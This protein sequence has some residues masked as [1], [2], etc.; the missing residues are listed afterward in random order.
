MVHDEIESASRVVDLFYPDEG[1]RNRMKKRRAAL[2]DLSKSYIK[3][4]ELEKVAD[5]ICRQDQYKLIRL[6]EELCDEPEIIAYRQDVLED[7]ISIPKLAGTVKQIV[8]I[9]IENDRG[10]IYQLSEP[11]SFTTLSEA[12][13]AFDAYVECVEIMHGFYLEHSGEIK[14]E[15]VKRLFKYFEDGYADED[16]NKMKKNLQELEE[17]LKNRIRSVTVAINLNENLVPV[18]A[19][20]IEYSAQKYMMKPS[21]FDRILYHGAK[22]PENTVE[23]LHT[24]YRN[25][26]DLSADELLINTVDET[27]FKELDSFTQK[28][29]KKLAKVMAQYQK[30]GVKDIFSIDHQLGFYIGAAALIDSVRAKGMGM[31]RPK[32]LPKEQ[33]RAEMKGLYDLVYY[34]EAAVYNLRAKDNKKSVVDNDI[35]FDE[36]AGFYILTGAN[37]GG[38]TT[39]V[40][41]I[42]ICQVLAQAGFYVPAREC[43][44]SCVDFVY[45]HFP[46]EEE[47]G[48][49]TSRFT[50]EIKE[51]KSIS[52]TVTNHSLLLMNESIQSTTPVECVEIAAKLVRLF[53]MLGV[54]GIF[55]THLIDIA[56]R[57]AELN[58]DP[59]L[60]TRI[61]SIVVTVDEKGERQYKIRKALPDSNVYAGE[62]FEKF[63][64]KEEDILRRAAE[65]KY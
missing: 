24:K 12:L 36:E 28:L 10:N 29:V 43:T 53:C 17:A 32:V 23:N 7:F 31:C 63:G 37:N 62:I 42:G 19:G 33:R 45:T 44:L 30:L 15:G 20:I 22:F 64:I 5:L 51:F 8:N 54:R 55:A 34:H 38:K 25:A 13:R 4:L 65:M 27:L 60:K 1:A 21:L 48:I 11:D 39:F 9:M 59:A 58:D 57:T 41:G 2:G 6:F 26:D 46:R 47:T 35:S 16:Y 61:E 52:E 3:D 40:R 49:N 56:Y 18:S 14:S 50:T